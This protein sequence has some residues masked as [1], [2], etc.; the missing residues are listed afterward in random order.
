MTLFL[1]SELLLVVALAVCLA[2]FWWK[3]LAEKRAFHVE[4]DKRDTLIGEL[5]ERV[6]VHQV[7][8]RVAEA[9]A[10]AAALRQEL[11][12]QA[13]KHIE[14]LKFKADKSEADRDEAI[15]QIRDV[16]SAQL[17]QF[18][19][20][21]SAE[22]NELKEA[23]ESM[24]GMVKI[25]DRWHN[26]MVPI[27][28]NNREL[29]D[30]N[31]AFASIVKMVVMLALNA[32]IEAARAGEAGRGFG[33]VADGVREL[34]QTASRLSQGYKVN[35]D[36][37]DLIATTTFQDLQ[38]SGNMIRTAFFELQRTSEKIRAIVDRPI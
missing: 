14:A 2:V 23:I 12:R 15:S 33:V 30:Q 9:C 29:K 36:K 18:R 20:A 24:L 11:E 19:A 4:L 22:H 1:N 8:A 17:R 34:A 31:E 10:E 28:A 6:P 16:H 13:S 27:L 37:N 26:E 7:E 32:A 3:S 21:L 35:L 38:A 25:I 5:S